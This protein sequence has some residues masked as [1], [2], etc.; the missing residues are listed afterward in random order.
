MIHGKPVNTGRLKFG[1][2][3]GDGVRTG[4]NTSLEAGIKIGIAR[5]ILPGSYV[6]KDLL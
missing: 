1:A 6:G 2:I 3:L 4:V 5:T